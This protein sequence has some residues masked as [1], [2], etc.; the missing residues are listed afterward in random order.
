MKNVSLFVALSLLA[1]PA[2]P[3]QNPPATRDSAVALPAIDVKGKNARNGAA[4]SLRVRPMQ[5]TL[6]P[7]TAEVT[8]R[9]AQET[10][11]LLDAQDVVKYLPSVFLRKRNYGDNQATLQT[12]TWGVSS[13]ARSLVFVDGV[14]ITALV[15]NNNTAGAPRWGLVSPNQIQRV[16]IMQGPFSAAYA[17]NSLGAVVEVTTRMPN[18][19]EA[20]LSQTGASQSFSLYG[21]DRSFGTLQTAG[22]VGS[23]FGKFA[24]WLSGNFQDSHSQPLSY[25]TSG[26]FPN[27]TTGGFAE[28]NKLNATA[29]ILGASGLL[30][31]GMTNGTLRA[32]YDFS[33]NLRATYTL[34]YW[35]N[36]SRS[37][38]ESFLQSGGQATFAGQA[39][40]A[41]G[42][43][44]L[45][46]RH[47][48]HALS[49]RTDAKRDWDFE[50]NGTIYRYDDSEQRSPTT[51][52]ATG[53]DF[54]TAGRIAV[55]DG[56]GWGTADAKATW[57]PLGGLKHTLSFGAHYDRYTLYNPTYNTTDWR[58]GDR[59][60]VAT[61]GDGKTSTQALWAQEAVRL[62]PALTLTVGGRWEHFRAYDGYNVNGTTTV[63]QPEVTMSKFSPK[64]SLAWSPS[65]DWSLT[66]SVGKAY[67]FPTP[68]EL[69][70]LISTGT[71]FT[72][73]DPNL[74]PDNALSAELRFERRFDAKGRVQLAVFQDDVHDAIIS[75]FLPLVPGSTTLY[76]YLAN[77]DHI[78]M[79]GVEFA[80]DARDLVVPGLGLQG[81]VTYVD[82]KTLAISGRAS[83]TAPEGSAIGKRVPNLPDW[84]ATAVATYRAAPRLTFSTA[85]RYSGDL[86]TTLD[87]ADVNPNTYQGFSSWVVADARA[88]WG[89]TDQVELSLGVDN[90]FNKKYFLFH[91]FPQRTLVGSVKYDL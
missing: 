31:T 53:T 60:T 76:S 41:S 67:R 77:V 44:R 74:K 59:G 7:V 9:R 16:D 49:L 69:Y 14:P 45:S 2:L 23:R 70:Q 30:H 85:V 62:T 63:T 71:T 79:R 19:L 10:V 52:T 13:S 55:M 15:A 35:Q 8:A 38:A 40:F 88:T 50:L 83:A 18:R 82:A 86:Y 33:S 64:G 89:V 29:N 39:G 32:A 78:R 68:A 72:S 24:F 48:S 84:R 17:G 27:G 11:N 51:A 26:S 4:D 47:L 36:K 91:P 57:H 22:Y 58:A 61:E 21:T 25:V 56:T 90:L 73:P 54:G 81:S 87:N 20:G 75:Q 28:K 43:N 3:A 37:Y 1:A 80:F 42:T 46:E 66:A 34:G 12:R 5:R 65:L 6:L